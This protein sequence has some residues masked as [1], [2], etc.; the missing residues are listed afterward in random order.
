MAIK[1][2]RVDVWS[3]EVEDRAGGLAK[4]LAPLAAAN[5]NLECIIGRRQAEKPGSAVV[6]LAPVA[7]TAVQAAAAKAGF[8]E[9]RTV[10]SLRI[11]GED[12]P[13]LGLSIASAVAEAGVSLRGISTMSLGPRFVGYLGFLSAEDMMKAEKALKTVS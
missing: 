7:G 11:E 5:A 1:V 10:P 4:A 12:R 8:H 2:T 3:A 9:K 13:G 6:F